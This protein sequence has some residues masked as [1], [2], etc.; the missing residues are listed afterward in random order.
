MLGGEYMCT[1][2]QVSS[3][4]N[5]YFV[6]FLLGGTFSANDTLDVSTRPD[7]YCPQ[8]IGAPLSLSMNCYIHFKDIV[9]NCY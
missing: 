1:C 9:L 6:D 4:F 5:Q 2:L 7:S 3:E 8:V